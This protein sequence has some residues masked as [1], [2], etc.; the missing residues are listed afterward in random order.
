MH[1]CV[2]VYML[3]F[4]GVGGGL[5]LVFNK[6]Q[7]QHP[8]NNHLP[9]KGTLRD[10]LSISGIDRSLC[11][12]QHSRSGAFGHGDHAQEGHTCCAHRAICLGKGGQVHGPKELGVP[13]PHGWC[14]G[15]DGPSW[16]QPK[17]SPWFIRGD[18]IQQAGE[19]QKTHQNWWNWRENL[20]KTQS[21]PDPRH[22]T[23]QRTAWNDV[24]HLET[25]KLYPSY[26]AVSWY[27]LGL[28]TG[29]SFKLKTVHLQKFNVV[30]H[31]GMHS[32]LSV[33]QTIP[34]QLKHVTQHIPPYWASFP[35]NFWL[36]LGGAVHMLHDSKWL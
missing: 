2:P 6:K 12:S 18:N 11:P 9:K 22:V 14:H 33:C 25:I 27:S 19:P 30:I 16:K 36:I 23:L 26:H 4:W 34:L 21:R 31:F 20:A 1:F 35:K 7:S 3:F 15:W 17:R 13:V 24:T 8:P 5:R 28:P 29:I 10:G 32:T